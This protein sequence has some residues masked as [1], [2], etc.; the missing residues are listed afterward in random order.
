[1]TS[2]KNQLTGMLTA[3]LL[4]SINAFFLSIGTKVQSAAHAR[5]VTATIPRDTVVSF[6]GV[7][8][9]AN[10]STEPSAL[11]VRATGPLSTPTRPCDRMSSPVVTPLSGHSAQHTTPDS[12]LSV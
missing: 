9:A 11:N 8:G 7:H 4:I 5:V 10:S 1:M 12:K 6:E 3:L 2:Y